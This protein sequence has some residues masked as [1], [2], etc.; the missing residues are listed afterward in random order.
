MKRD[1]VCAPPS[2]RMRRKAALPRA[3]PGSRPARS[4][5]RAPAA[6]TISTPA[7][8]V[9]ADAFGGD[10]QPP[11][12]VVG[13]HPGVGRQAPARI[14]HDARR[15]RPAHAPDG[16]LRVVGDR[17]ADADQHRIDQR[18][19]PVQMGEPGRAVDVF[20]M[21]GHRGDA[22]VDRLADLADHD[23]VVDRA[24]PQRPEPGFPGLRQRCVRGAKIAWNFGPRR[25]VTVGVIRLD[26]IR[27]VFVPGI[28]SKRR[29]ELAEL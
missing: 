12:A 14:E 5:R 25:G 10:D 8:S 6:P 7:G 27:H 20:G 15:A 3:P 21:A 23:E 28:A 22:A 9:G 1:T 11:D 26:C 18:A 4:R 24:A 16:E 19:Q 17:R 29:R 2:I 13:E